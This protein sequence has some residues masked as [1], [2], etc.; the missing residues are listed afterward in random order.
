MSLNCLVLLALR[1]DE[2]FQ[3]KRELDELVEK[4]RVRYRL[5]SAAYC[6]TGIPASHRS[7][8]IGAPAASHIGTTPAQTR[9]AWSSASSSTG[10]P[11]R[12]ERCDAG[13]P[14]PQYA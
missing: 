3:R 5:Y 6:G 9:S 4:F 2:A 8:R 1:S 14:V 11:I 10:A 12:D 7:S 13:I